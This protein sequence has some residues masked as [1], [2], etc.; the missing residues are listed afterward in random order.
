VKLEADSYL[1]YYGPEWDRKI[2]DKNNP[3]F[4]K[5][6]VANLVFLDS[7]KG[8]K[9][10]LDVGCGTGDLSM[11]LA[12]SEHRH[13][14]IGI[15]P[16]KSMIEVAR[17]HVTQRKLH[18]I[19]FLIC[20]GRFLPFKQLC[21]DALVSRGDAFVFLVPQKKALSEFRRVLKNGAVIAIEVDNA[22]W[23]P[24]KEI[25]RNFE[26]MLDGAIAYSV[27]H[28][29][30]K[31]NHTKV[32]YVLNPHSILAKQ[33]REDSQFV[34]V[35]RL[36][37]S[38]PVD[39]IKKETIEIRHGVLTHWPTVD[40]LKMMF[41]KAGFEKIEVLGDGLLMSLLLDGDQETTRIMKTHPGL[42]FE[43]ER[44]L[45]PSIDPRKASTII[46]KATVS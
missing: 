43:I 46:L 32:F 36:Q 24:G 4:W 8:S 3:N 7:L 6:G 10:I 38:I 13:Y 18:G 37:R 34:R 33:I 25:S 12:E 21:F 26:K 31:R 39:E 35:G 17:Q 16:V 22:R 19:H 9:K 15:D 45:I 44:K 42:F 1:G 40:G 20:D 5:Y 11:F 41:R 29:D 23:E 27:E 14:V 28:F 2:K 30:I